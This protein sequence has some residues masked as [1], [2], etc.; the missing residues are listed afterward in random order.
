MHTHIPHIQLGSTYTTRALATLYGKNNRIE[1]V[2]LNRHER[3]ECVKQ[4]IRRRKKKHFKVVVEKWKLLW[5]EKNGQL[6]KNEE[7]NKYIHSF[8]QDSRAT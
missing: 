6:G 7:S 3:E 2:K 4:R 5:Y 8:I 1:N